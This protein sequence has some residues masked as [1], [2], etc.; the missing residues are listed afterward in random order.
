MSDVRRRA[1]RVAPPGPSGPLRG[2]LDGPGCGG[3]RAVRSATSTRC[4]ASATICSTRRGA[5]RPTSRTTASA[6][7]RE[8]TALVER[9]TEGLLE[10][11]LPGARQLRARGARTSSGDVD[12]Q[13]AQGHRARATRSCSACSSAPGSSASTRSGA[14]FDPN[15]HEAVHAGRR[16]RRAA[17]RRRVAHRLEVEG[18]RAASRDG[19]GHEEDQR[20]VAAQREWFEKDYYAVLGVPSSATD[21]ELS[22]AYKKLAKEHHPDA[23]PGNTEAE[24][25]FKESLRRV[26][27]ARR[28]RRSARSTTRCGA[29]SRRASVPAGPGSGRAAFGRPGGQHVRR[30]TATAA[31]S[32]TCSATCSAAAGAARPRAR[33][34]PAARPGSRD[35]V[36]PVVRRRGAAASRARCGSAPTR[37]A[38]RARARARRRARCPRRARS[39]TAAARSPSTRVRSRS[40]RCAR[41]AAGAVRSSR[42]RARRAAGR[43]VEVRAREVKVRVPGR[44]RRRAAHP[45][46]GPRRAP[47]RTA[48]RPATSTCRAR[49]RRTR[50]SGAAA[51]TSRCGCR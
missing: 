37:R 43:G 25:R 1:T 46:E 15:E 29:W 45:R 50:C 13:G 9:A 22:R 40:R 5:C 10:Q 16:R 28:H 36:A 12:E 44:R 8:Q 19:E 26:R 35:R 34:G 33:D 38:R 31:A 30:S 47:A 27:R 4:N 17:R 7:L 39:V 51:T 48:V 49:A 18:P 11:L 42:R 14:P 6:M 3:S 20:I 24:E 32:A 23:N 41:R 21:K 2:K